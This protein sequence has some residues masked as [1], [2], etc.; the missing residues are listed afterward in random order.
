MHVLSGVALASASFLEVPLPLVSLNKN[1]N[2]VLFLY[3]S[4]AASPDK[5]RRV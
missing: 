2:S 3:A 4:R 1:N 5:G